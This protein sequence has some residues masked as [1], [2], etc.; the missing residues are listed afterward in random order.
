MKIII[1]GAGRIGRNLSK[2]LSEEGNEVY[3][4]E[5]D[6][7]VARRFA[8]KLDVKIIIGNG[9][10]P[11]TLQKA[12]VGNSDLVLAVT[13]SDETNLVVCT[14]A[15]SFGAKRR[16]A[17]V[18]NTALRDTI[19]EYGLNIFNVNEIINPELVAAEAIVKTVQ[20]PGAS[21]VGD[22]ASGRILLRA[23]DLSETSPL[24]GSKI[25]DFADDDFPWPFL[26]ISIVRDSEVFI[27]K[28]DTVLQ[29]GDHVYVLLPKHSLAEF[30]T[31]VNPDIKLPKKVVIYGASITGRQL[32]TS[33][34]PT[35]KNVIL[36]EEDHDKAQEVSESIQG[37]TVI[38]G[39]ASESE[40]LNECGVEAAD[41]FI[42]TSK[43]DAANLISSVLAK[44]MGAKM[45]I[46]T[47]QQLEYMSIVDAL[48]IDAI[49]NPH[50]LAVEQILQMAR[51]RSISS[52]TKLMECD[53]EAM[54]LVPETNSPITKNPLKNI[55]L[56][57]NSIVGAV[58]SGQEVKLANG[59]TN[60]K[61]GEKVIVFCQDSAI[62]K[63]QSLF[64]RK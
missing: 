33:L 21:E 62:K 10:D 40:I 30:V 38:N 22:F 12:D 41:A 49:I 7:D 11:T 26:I 14:L 4:L 24:C 52:V 36:V 16:I 42:A 47:T 31:F 32:A 64:T 5:Q 19:A 6:K 20:T 17:R 37:V 18:R 8:D 57:K 51:G 28:G 1:V 3:L 61:E 27:P 9:S 46:I 2:T 45:T 50:Y 29:S 43:N 34:S 53:A 13:T 35:I 59:E 48:N 44:K 63:V 15:A 25:G 56:P 54:E 23:F 58:C 55:K 39:S 60:I